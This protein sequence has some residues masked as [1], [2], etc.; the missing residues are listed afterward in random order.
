[1]FVSCAR[2]NVIAKSSGYKN[3]TPDGERSDDIMIVPPIAKKL[4]TFLL[5]GVLSYSSSKS[6]VTANSSKC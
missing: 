4:T 3:Y 5:C 1:M 2:L 6:P